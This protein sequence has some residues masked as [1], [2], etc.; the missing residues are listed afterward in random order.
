LGRQVA[1]PLRDVRI[2]QHANDH[3]LVILNEAKNPCP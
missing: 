1:S 2:R 3:L